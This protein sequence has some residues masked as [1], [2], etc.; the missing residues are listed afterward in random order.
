M[1]VITDRLAEQLAELERRQEESQL[2]LER[3][4]ERMKKSVDEL[5]NLDD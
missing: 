3:F 4:L 2:R 5:K 1:G